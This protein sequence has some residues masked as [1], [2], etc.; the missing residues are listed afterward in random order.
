[1][2][3]VRL[4]QREPN[5]N[6]HIN[7][8]SALPAVDAQDQEDA[9]QLLRALAA[10]VRPVM[11]AHG[12]EVNSFEEYEHNM[13]FAGRNW[14][15]GET[16]ELVLRGKSG[17]FLSV[18][19]L[20]S[21]FCHELAHI[22]HANHGRDFQALWS[23]LRSEVQDLQRKGY[24]GDGYWSSGTRLS[25]SARV[26]GQSLDAGDLPE[27]V[28]GGAQT[29]ARPTALRRRRRAGPSNYSGAQT[30]KKRKAGS[31]VTAQGVFRGDGHALNEDVED[32]AQKKAGAGFR[33]KAGS[34]R[35]REERALAAERRVQAL[36]TRG[37]SS[38]APASRDESSGEEEDEPVPETDEDRRRTMLDMMAQTDLEGLKVSRTDFSS[39]FVYTSPGSSQ[40][41]PPDHPEEAASRLQLSTPLTGAGS[42]STSNTTSAKGKGVLTN[43][44]K[45]ATLE[46][47]ADCGGPE[48]SRKKRPQVPY[49][50]LVRDEVTHR[51]KEALGMASTDGGR[52]LGEA[53]TMSAARDDGGA[54][55][56]AH[57]PKRDG[58]SESGWACLV[59]TLSNAPGH[60]A[61]SACAT[62]RGESVWAGDA[63]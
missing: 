7:F 6:P 24:Y 46:D 27:Y 60:L 52:R 45:H 23:R 39:D 11:K 13:V 26:A 53:H 47:W 40:P 32:V 19:W 55:S 4:N 59:C 3:H 8:I 1:M 15:N 33:K 61:C 21:T 44:S 29:R 49:G 41:Q 34:K 18:S 31:R 14:N 62:P 2:V 12:F 16:V 22:Q 28:C 43:Q 50:A 54:R 9:R 5:P 58:G 51:T 38:T 25:D 37:T 17:A 35:A 36:Q 63:V 48:P 42:A 30:A 56:P 10:Q 57:A 20:M